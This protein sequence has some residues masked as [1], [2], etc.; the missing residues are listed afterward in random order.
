MKLL[1]VVNPSSG[2]KRGV[3]WQAEIRNYFEGSSHTVELLLLEKDVDVKAAIDAFKPDRVVAVGGDGTVNML[4]HIVG[5]TALPIGILPAGSANGMAKE[6]NLPNKPKEAIDTA[7]NSSPKPI[8]VIRINETELCLHLSDLGLN[9][10][11]IKYFE[12]GEL[13]GMLGYAKGLLKVLRNSERLGVAVQ[14]KTDEVTR[15]A[16]MVALA[17]ATKYG[18]GTIINHGGE[19]D[20]GLFEVVIVRRLG[21]REMLKA[22]IRNQ[23]QFHPKG[24]EVLQAKS[25]VIGTSH[26]VHFQIDGEYKGKVSGVKAEILPGYLQMLF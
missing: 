8:D 9:A 21:V 13:R 17:N 2:R 4:A 18:T 7:V 1:F 22:L 6:L 3:D 19:L 14:T 20:D 25:V 23:K 5:G 15:T 16:M 24:I 10:Q 11:L 26:K 12:D